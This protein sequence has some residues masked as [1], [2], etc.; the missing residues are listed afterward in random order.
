M[1]AASAIQKLACKGKHFS[2]GVLVRPFQEE[3]WP[4]WQR[5]FPGQPA[6]ALARVELDR[7]DMAGGGYG[8][9]WLS[10]QEQRQLAGYGLEKRRREWLGGRLAAKWTVE[11]FWGRKERDWRDIGIVAGPDGRPGVLA[12]DCPPPPFLS[13]SHSG[14]CAASLVADRPCGLDVQQVRNRI[15]VVRER[16]VLAGEE[17]I[18]WG[19]L[20]ATMGEEQVLTL[21]WA[22]KE[23]VRKM[24]W[25]S[26]LPFLTAIRLVA[27]ATGTTGGEVL[28]S[29]AVARAAEVVEDG[30]IR[31]LALMEN[32][33][34][35]AFGCRMEQGK[36]TEPWSS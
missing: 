26:P 15:L 7:L 11:R 17:D 1:H 21:L 29:F 14:G 8:E 34:A 6:L 31:V 32:E 20:P 23:A 24:A 28:C 30:P 12:F 9:R 3:R 27:A 36:R 33:M 25:P 22:G 4:E 35:W 10:G 16:F 5:R 18:L 19:G 13:I 2:G